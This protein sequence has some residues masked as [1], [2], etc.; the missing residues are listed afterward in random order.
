M[1]H[2]NVRSTMSAVPGRTE[3]IGEI[4]V[5]MGALAPTDV[6]R[7]V[8]LQAKTGGSFGHVAVRQS[9]VTVDQ[10][11]AA[12]AYQF[13]YVS[14]QGAD[15]PTGM[16][17]ELIMLF[18]S[19]GRNAERI[20]ILRSHLMIH[21]FQ[22][23]ERT[24][25]VTGVGRGSGASYVAANLAT[26]IAQLGR[27]VLLV[28]TNLRAPRLRDLFGIESNVG[29][30]DALAGRASIDS[31]LMSNLI[32]NMAIL[33]A[34]TIPPNPQ[35]LLGSPRFQE[36]MAQLKTVFGVIILD[37]CGEE[38]IA[39]AD[40]VWNESRNVLLVAR[41]GRSRY[42]LAQHMAESVRAMGGNVVG[43]VI[44]NY[45]GPPVRRRRKHL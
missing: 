26:S 22:N 7:V 4:L 38:G 16:S 24:L 36:L 5:R 44:N 33:P 43:T 1:N 42:A 40:Q 39:D 8:E 14:A 30:S 10:V 25:A 13:G 11:R 9:L 27:R 37:T 6:D 28:D 35:E 17:N 20:R 32:E 12:L 19:M 45:A 29:L 21:H 18:D 3:R 31:V 34:G 15:I 23:G 41:Q 2:P